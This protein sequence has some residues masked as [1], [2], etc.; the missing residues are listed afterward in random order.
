M[1]KLR[2]ASLWAWQE[3]PAEEAKA[4]RQCYLLQVTNRKIGGWIP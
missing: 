1:S 4:F 2:G 3:N